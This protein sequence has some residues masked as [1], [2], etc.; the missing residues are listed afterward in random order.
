MAE[1][2][3][4]WNSANDEIQTEEKRKFRLLSCGRYGTS[5]LSLVTNSWSRVP[6]YCG[7]WNECPR[8]ADIRQ[9]GVK[10]NLEYCSQFGDLSCTICDPKQASLLR[11]RFM[12][13]SYPIGGES[14]IVI[15]L[16]RTGDELIEEYNGLKLK[17]VNLNDNDFISLISKTPAHKRTT[18]FA[19]GRI[20]QVKSR[21]ETPVIE[22]TDDV[23]ISVPYIHSGASEA[24]HDIAR[25]RALFPVH[26]CSTPGQVNQLLYD[27]AHRYVKEL[28]YLGINTTNIE[29][30]ET[31][32]KTYTLLKNGVLEE[33]NTKEVARQSV[34]AELMCY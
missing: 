1:D 26:G 33:S 11:K 10:H 14:S 5:T 2:I 3:N 18:G 28:G 25:K 7:I 16:Q 9:N 12:I 32:A 27:M 20:E 24:Q 17:P 31:T 29:F 15:V 23:V 13:T 8:C 19:A 34:I 30:I 4:S 6:H 22:G 21:F